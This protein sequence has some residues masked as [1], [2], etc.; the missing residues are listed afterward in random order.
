M[1]R[2]AMGLLLAGIAVLPATMVLG[3]AATPT[4][5]AGTAVDSLARPPRDAPYRN[6]RLPV[7]DRV[8]DL[9]ARM[10]LEEKIAQLLTVWDNKVEIQNPDDSFDPARAS[11]RY[12]NGLGQLA[13]PSDRRGPA[14][15]RT[16]RRRSVADSV[17]YVNAVQRWAIEQTRLGIPVLMHE[18]S[19][20]GLA[21]AD[22]TSFPQAIALA[23]SFDPD[24]AREVNRI[25]AQQASA[26]GVHLVLSPVV[27]VAR[28]PRWGRIE[29]TFG[30]DPYLAGEMGVASVEG[31][32]GSGT[33]RTVIAPGRVLATLKHMTGHGQPEGGINV[34]P[35]PIA[36]RTLREIFLPP[37]ENVISRTSIA[38]VMPSYNEV[39][40]VPSHANS[41]LLTDVLRREWG[42]QGAVVSDY[43]AIAEMV[44]RHNLA[45][46]IPEAARLSLAAGVDSDLPTGNAFSTLL[47]QVRAGTI[48][49]DQ[50]DRAV[51]NIL[52]LKFRSGMFDRPYVRLA[53]AQTTNG[54]EAVALARRAAERSLILLKNDGTLPLA[55]PA[56]GGAR[57][58]I[59]VIGPNASVARQ[60]GYT[61]D[62]RN[63][64]SPLAGIRALVGDRA[65]IVHAEGVRITVDDDWWADEV[66]LAPREENL[67]LIEQ[68]VAAAR[69]ADTIV[70]FIGDTE[71]TS[72]E[73]W[74]DNHL[75]DRASL[76]L[77]GEQQL[78]FDRLRAL[79]RPIVVVLA[80]GRPPSY[81]AVVE[82]ANAVIES[83]Y[84]GEQQGHAI[85][86]ALFGR[87]NPG[88]RLPVTVA[89]HVGQLPIFYNYKP[90][91]RRGY[92]FD[93]T[94]PLFP[95]GFGLSYTTFTQSAPRLS[96][97]SIAAG[98]S[99]TVSVDV[100]NT[101]QRE[102][103]EVVQVYVRDRVSSVTRPVRELKAFRRITLA[104]G[105][106]R[107]VDFQLGIEAFRMWNRQMQRV[108]EPGDFDIMVGPNSA[109]T[110]TVALTITSR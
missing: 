44:S 66:Q 72:R 95:F 5:Q 90:S 108:I 99:V 30:E 74:A 9:L 96:Q 101:G 70:L 92:L 16:V 87:V 1:R 57:P 39:D 54:P 20:H 51:R 97:T 71:Q 46:D 2:I 65:D 26:R 10:T 77:V 93:T 3:Q 85:A 13:R 52:T 50:V 78:L 53:T 8:A 45:T 21:V 11:A 86:D 19:L 58:R 88:G 18:E 59:A 12:P 42:F 100:Q 36:E 106:R 14:S 79:G 109:Q 104:P 40:G 56:A 24:L 27:D 55:M 98:N 64:I 25:I 6:A 81:P 68:A 102:G 103:D 15:P 32:Q 28:D 43:Y 33:A 83:W 76:D 49:Q 110:Q 7:A 80:N 63:T 89:R 82:G 29:E 22:G 62:P 75:G 84:G 94:A 91:A 38:A 67:R 73:A 105:E 41:W 35:A 34:G 17:A 23:S 48:P 60:G 4:S 61:G 31:L 69:N 47:A 37:F 107:T